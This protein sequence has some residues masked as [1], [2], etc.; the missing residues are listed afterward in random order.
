MKGI[1][2]LANLPSKPLASSATLKEDR[3]RMKK[4]DAVKPISRQGFLGV[5]GSGGMDAPRRNN[6]KLRSLFLLNFPLSE[7]ASVLD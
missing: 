6:L 7:V 3:V 5:R 1:S 2:W 4:V